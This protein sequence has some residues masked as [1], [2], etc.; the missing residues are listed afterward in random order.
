MLLANGC[1][2]VCMHRS[3]RLL[4][5]CFC[6]ALLQV[7]GLLRTLALTCTYY[8]VHTAETTVTVTVSFM[9]GDTDHVLEV[10]VPY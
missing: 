7:D 10:K 3:S 5:T 6:M 4:Y 9:P 2:Y 8:Y 1:V